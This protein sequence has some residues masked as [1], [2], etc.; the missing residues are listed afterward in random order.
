MG[1]ISIGKGTDEIYCPECGKLI[2]RS[3]VFCEHCGVKLKD[4]KENYSE[5]AQ[6]KK[7][8]GV[9]P[10]SKAVAIILAVFFGYWTWLYTYKRDSKKFWVYLCISLPSTVGVII[11]LNM[12]ISGYSSPLAYEFLVDYGTWVWLYFLVSASASIWALINSIGRPESF[13]NNYPY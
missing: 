11:L 8:Y 6:Q 1:E 4:A 5:P 13:Y 3:A 10:K 2:R 9:S 12:V 7:E